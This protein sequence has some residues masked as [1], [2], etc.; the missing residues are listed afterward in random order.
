MTLGDGQLLLS[1][2]GREAIVGVQTGGEVALVRVALDGDE[3][4]ALVSG[5]TRACVPIAASG[6]SVLFAAF[7]FTDP[8]DLYVVDPDT[9][10]EKRLTH[11]NDELL[12]ELALPTAAPLRFSSIDG[13]AVEG[14]FLQPA[15]SSRPLPTILSIHGGPHGAWGASFHFDHLMLVGAGYGVLLVNHRA[16]TGYGDAFA[17]AIMGDW[18]NLDYADLMAGVDHAVEEGLADPDRLGVSG[19]SGGGNLTGWVIGH[20]DRFKAACPENPVF[21]WFSMYGTSD[22]GASFSLSRARWHPVRGRGRLPTLLTDHLRAPVYHSDVVHA[23][24]ARLPLSRRTDGAV[25]HSSARERGA[26]GNAPLPEH[27]AHRLAGRPDR[28]PADA[29]RG[30]ARLDEPLRT[31]RDPACHVRQ[32]ASAAPRPCSRNLRPSHF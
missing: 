5:G 19:L 27:A 21:N 30:T 22:V 16:S 3:S 23:A 26:G 1:D 31:G 32:L 15:D 18:G 8:G 20:T 9:G 24:R 25:L 13:A 29:Q 28:P 6:R 17:T 12:S 14:W 10:T 2:D 11:I 4:H 7:G